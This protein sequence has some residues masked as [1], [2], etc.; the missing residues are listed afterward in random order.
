M[1]AKAT[2]GPMLSS[3]N[4]KLVL[5]LYVSGMSQKS[6]EA[7]QNIRKMCDEHL[8]GVFDLEIID[9][10]KNPEV[11]VEQQV[12]F[13]PSL[14]KRRP[15]PQKIFIGTFTDTEKVVRGLGIAFK[16]RIK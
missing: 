1:K 13:S 14:I 16:P 4:E 9:I 15:L 3:N 12:I 6:M 7:I 5:Q 8:E 11:A 10:Y 2:P